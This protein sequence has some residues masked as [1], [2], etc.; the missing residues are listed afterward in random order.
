MS[1]IKLDDS[2]ESQSAVV[3]LSRI[4]YGFDERAAFEFFNQFGEIKGV[5]FPRSKKTGRSKGYM[6][7]LFADRGVAEECV[8]V[9]DGYLMFKKQVKCIILPES[10]EIIQSKFVQQPKKFKFIPWKTIFA[11][12]FNKNNDVEYKKQKIRKLFEEDEK[13]L[14]KLREKHL[15]FEFP[16]F[17]QFVTDN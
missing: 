14:Q 17:K 8:K 13:K 5:C 12:R 11:K 16:T 10:H 1:E 15:D 3:Y 9:V 4:P 2:S 6:F 7:V